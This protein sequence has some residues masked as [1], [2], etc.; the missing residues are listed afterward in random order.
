M[1][2]DK[3][4]PTS[5]KLSLGAGLVLLI[6]F[7][8]VPDGLPSFNLC[9]FKALTGLPCPGCGL[10]HAFCAISHGNIGDAWL[11]NPFSFLFYPLALLFLLSP[12]L[13]RIS[14]NWTK[15]ERLNKLANYTVPVVLIAMVVYD[16]FRVIK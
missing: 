2:K 7:I 3:A 14:P 4:I 5:W 10:T 6:S 16:I 1:N 11:F 13:V 15:T 12:A 9:W 8:V